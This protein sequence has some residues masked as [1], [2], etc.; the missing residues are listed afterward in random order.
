MKSLL[1]VTDQSHFFPH[2]YEVGGGICLPHP[3]SLSVQM[4]A[5][6]RNINRQTLGQGKTLFTEGIIESRLAGIYTVIWWRD[7]CWS[8]CKRPEHRET[9]LS[10]YKRSCV[11]KARC[12][13]TLWSEKQRCVVSLVC[14]YLFIYLFL[15]GLHVSIMQLVP[16]LLPIWFPAAP[17]L[18]FASLG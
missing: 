6:F 4:N 10:V 16:W 18:F 7:S 2:I 5:L 11:C 17:K 15:E 9:P 8:Q 12:G 13:W 14:I 3:L 1:I